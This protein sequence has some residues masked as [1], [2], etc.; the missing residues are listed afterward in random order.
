MNDNFSFDG[1]DAADMPLD[2]SFSSLPLPEGEAAAGFHLPEMTPAQEQAKADSPKLVDEW[3]QDVQMLDD[4]GLNGLEERAGLE[5]G[6][7]LDAEAA[8]EE[9]SESFNPQLGDM[10]SV[11]RKGSMLMKGVEE[12]KREQARDRQN[13]V[14][15]LLRAGRNDQE[16]LKR[17]AER[18]GE[19]AVSRLESANE[20][21]RAYMLGM[22][23]AEVLGDGDSDAGFQIY[24]NTHDLW[25]KGIVSPEQ[26]W[27]D[28]RER[29][30]DIVE[31]EDRQRVERERRISDL[32]GVVSRY[33]SGEQYSLSADE[34]MALFHAGVSVASMEKAR[35]GVR[36]MEAFEQDSRLYHDDIADDLFGIIGNDDDALMMLCNLLR[37]RSRST[38]HDRLGMGGAE[39]RADEAYQEVM[40]NSNPMVVAMA[41]P[42]IQNAKMASGLF[43]TGKVAGVKTK[44]SLERALQNMETPEQEERR[45]IQELCRIKGELGRTGRYGVYFD[46]TGPEIEFWVEEFGKPGF[47]ICIKHQDAGAVLDYVRKRCDEL[48][49]LSTP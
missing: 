45:C 32:N 31:R 47:L 12:R 19:D 49:L 14:M 18:W 46:L 22:R 7:S 35:R 4:G 27:K 26:V 17:I 48:N 39:K 13:M 43:M 9:G 25:G 34:R 10:D 24:K 6:V 11:R 41:G 23:L 5:A 38:A 3:R 2:L 37:N 8:E 33:V 44:R 29:G 16:A 1:A 30:K 42:Q 28:F 40:E 36:L 15:N 20:E 21:E